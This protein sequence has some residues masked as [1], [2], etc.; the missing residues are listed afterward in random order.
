MC[1]GR[2]N[3]DRK[4]AGRSPSY[5]SARR[6][7]I[8]ELMS[9]FGSWFNLNLKVGLRFT[10]G[11]RSVQGWD[12]R[13]RGGGGAGRAAAPPLF[14]APAPL[15]ENQ[16]LW[17]YSFFRFSMWKNYFQL[18]ALPLFTLLRGPWITVA[19]TSSSGSSRFPIWGRGWINLAFL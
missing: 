12:Y 19:S 8:G 15:F 6:P 16:I 5:S 9:D 7:N 10:E 14:C 3:M 11:L 1:R 17:F 13:G 2:E 18:S 4:K